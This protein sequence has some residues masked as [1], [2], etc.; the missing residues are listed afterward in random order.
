M[1]VAALRLQV[2]LGALDEGPHM[3]SR[4]TPG[5]PRGEVAQEIF[6]YAQTLRKDLVYARHL[7]QAAP[8]VI[9]QG[10]A[11]TVAPVHT[12]L[13]GGP[14]AQQLV[15]DM[16]TG[17]HLLFN[18]F[19]RVATA[20]GH[21]VAQE[22]DHIAT[23]KLNGQ[24]DEAAQR[25]L[26]LGLSTLAMA[27]PGV[28]A[29]WASGRVALAT[30]QVARV[31]GQLPKVQGSVHQVIAKASRHKAGFIKSVK[32]GTLV[33]AAGAVGSA[34][35]SDDAVKIY[36]DRRSHQ[37]PATLY[38]APRDVKALT[39]KVGPMS[40]SFWG[41]TNVTVGNPIGTAEVRRAGKRK[42]VQNQVVNEQHQTGL[43]LGAGLHFGT[44]HASAY[45]SRMLQLFNVTTTG[46]ADPT[47]ESK[48]LT[49]LATQADV[50][51]I[52]WNST[53]AL[54]L[55]P[56]ALKGRKTKKGKHA[57]GALSNDGRG[58]LGAAD[59]RQS[60]YKTA[61]TNPAFGKPALESYAPSMTFNP[62]GGL[63]RKAASK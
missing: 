40:A 30:G 48:S 17:V 54:A 16:K 58:R 63:T 9:Q 28:G 5:Q 1:P 15:Q 6:E 42:R 49:R 60:K 56:I 26:D 20:V 34:A 32:A 43:L 41:G 55:G 7:A 25:E 51:W 62:L 24:L 36:F 23:L 11:K 13:R 21:A 38:G 44:N 22:Q 37:I 33:A 35:L 4:I 14:Q 27:M 57:A 45:G 59:E 3:P 47:P 53:D 31:V 8:Q 19:D 2:A 12:L 46:R 50:S 61:N 29:L 18:D 10:L 52:Y 39:V